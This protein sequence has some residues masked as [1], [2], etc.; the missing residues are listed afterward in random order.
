MSARNAAP[1]GPY[2]PR[3]CMAVNIFAVVICTIAGVLN[4][5]T[6]NFT[7]TNTRAIRRNRGLATRPDYAAIARME[8]DIWGQAFTHAG[9]PADTAHADGLHALG[10]AF[11][12]SSISLSAP[13]CARCGSTTAILLAR[14]LCEPCYRY[15]KIM[16][17]R[18]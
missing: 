18:G 8:R 5:L 6:G 11:R 4:S 16:P 3:F 13:G 10:A 15:R 17:G 2:R 9:A 1:A 7:V 12:A 14:G